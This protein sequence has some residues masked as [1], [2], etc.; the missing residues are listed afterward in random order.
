[1]SMDRRQLPEQEYEKEK[2][3]TFENNQR[4]AGNP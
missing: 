3:I 4:N 2:I 1:M